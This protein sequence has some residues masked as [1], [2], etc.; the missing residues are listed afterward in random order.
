[1]IGESALILAETADLKSKL[2][3]KAT[4][5]IFTDESNS[6]NHSG[7]VGQKRDTIIE[8]LNEVYGSNNSAIIREVVNS[9]LDYKSEIHDY[10]AFRVMHGVIENTLSC[11]T[12]LSRSELDEERFSDLEGLVNKVKT[13][14]NNTPNLME[15]VAEQGIKSNATARGITQ[16]MQ[17]VIS[18]LKDKKDKNNDLFTKLVRNW[19]QDKK[20]HTLMPLNNVPNDEDYI[21]GLFGIIGYT[22]LTFSQ[23]KDASIFQHLKDTYEIKDANKE[24]GNITTIEKECNE[25]Y[26]KLEEAEQVRRQHYDDNIGPL[27]DQKNCLERKIPDGYYYWKEAIIPCSYN[28]TDT[29]DEDTKKDLRMK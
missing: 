2:R 8:H 13:A 5:N 17:S 25:S 24:D 20:L 4:H 3:K 22:N 7:T 6:G 23:K 18:I 26:K 14:L 19:N 1:M 28:I 10:S 15:Y 27:V 16:Q 11:L 21:L 29:L 9:N 12:G